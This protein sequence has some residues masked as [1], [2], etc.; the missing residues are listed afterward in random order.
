[1]TTKTTSSR[2]TVEDLKNESPF[3]ISDICEKFG[4][5]KDSV[6]HFMS[7]NNRYLHFKGEDVCDG[8][9][10]RPVK[11]YE[12][13]DFIECPHCGKKIKIDELSEYR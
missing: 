7:R 11:K 9:I 4:V 12:Y 3:F 6:I 8:D 1:M 13:T 2:L 10:G 5:T